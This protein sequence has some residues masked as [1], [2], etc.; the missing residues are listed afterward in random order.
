M[1]RDSGAP[2]YDRAS[3]WPIPFAAGERVILAHQSKFDRARIPLVWYW[4]LLRE[5]DGAGTTS[6]DETL[7]ESPRIH[8]RYAQPIAVHMFVDDVSERKKAMRMGVIETTNLARIVLSR[9]EARRVGQHLEAHDVKDGLVRDAERADDPIFVPRA[10]DIFL[11]RGADYFEV[12]QV[13]EERFGLQSFITTWK[14]TAVL[15]R[16]DIVNPTRNNLPKPP[17]RVPTPEA[18]AAWRG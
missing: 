16:D 4:R 15:F 13:V 8:R 17:T 3:V 5:S 11:L 18:H 2:A 1:S 12:Q 14:G 10:E 9:A 7:F 6:P